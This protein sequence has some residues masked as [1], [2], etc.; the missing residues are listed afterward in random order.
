MIS[1]FEITTSRVVAAL[2]LAACSTTF[3]ATIELTDG[4]INIS[5]SGAKY[6]LAYPQPVDGAK[7]NV[8]ITD[9]KI[10]GGRAKI[11]YEGGGR[12]DLSVNDGE[13]A[14]EFMN[15]PD[16]TRL[17]YETF[18]IPT[19]SGIGTKWA[20]DDKTGEFPKE[21][22]PKPFLRQGNSKTVELTTSA[23]AKIAMRVPDY[24]FQQLT[25]NRE[26]NNSVF[27]W[28]CWIPLYPENQRIVMKVGDSAA[29]LAA[30]SEKAAPAKVAAK[31]DLAPGPELG[32]TKILKWKDGRQAVFML[33]FDDS[34][35]GHIKNAIPELKRRGMVGTFYINPGNGPFKNKQAAW[36]KDV[37]AAGMEMG[38]HTFTHSHALSVEDF[39]KE[40]TLCNDEINKCYPDRKTPRLISY[41]PPGGIPKEKWLISKD[42]VNASITKLHLIERPSYFGPPIHQ[43][44]AAE[45]VKVVDQAL[46]KGDMGYLVFH[47][48]G[49]DWL[50]TPMDWFTAILDEL[51]KHRD[52]FW[53]TDPI[54][55][56]KYLTERRASEV[57]T[58]SAD[59]K[60]IRLQLSATTDP[61]LYDLSLTLAT[62]VPPEWKSC[63]VTQGSVGSSVPSVNGVVRYSAIPGAAEIF[64]RAAPATN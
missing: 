54:S 20:M 22:P 50:T 35:E 52:Q 8:A 21:K 33:E 49:G 15:V 41:G 4:G 37:P 59:A 12:A 63:S 56:H 9:K 58:I 42:E 36:E 25:D 44:S 31:E 61:V 27:Q 38:N 17:I 46:A 30:K 23:G 5:T 45:C 14:V 28:Q 55:W 40:I 48:V 2:L 47:G 34:C 57:K 13:I 60:E 39:E 7:K 64:L 32:A 10:E 43:H 6:L 53:I 19:E 29:A 26:W 1:F 24:S 11:S 51:D 18:K 16:G 62:R 3:A